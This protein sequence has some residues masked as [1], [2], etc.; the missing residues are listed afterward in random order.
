MDLPSN[1]AT[2][3]IRQII[4]NAEQPDNAG[5]F[6]LWFDLEGLEA[7]EL[8]EKARIAAAQSCVRLLLDAYADTPNPR[9][10]RL[11]CL[12]QIYRP[13]MTLK[14]LAKTKQQQIEFQQL[15]QELRVI[16]HFFQTHH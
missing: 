2:T 6:S 7:D 10:W 13:L 9:H 5:L 15:M 14:R 4:V 16:S 11:Q 1:P 3:K 8:S 12:D